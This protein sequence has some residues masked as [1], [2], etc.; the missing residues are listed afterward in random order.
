MRYLNLKSVRQQF[1]QNWKS[2]LWFQKVSVFGYLSPSLT[3]RYYSTPISLKNCYL[4]RLAIQHIY[5][6][7]QSK[8][9]TNSLHK[10]WFAKNPGTFNNLTSKFKTSRTDCT[11]KLIF[12]NSGTVKLMLQ[13]LTLLLKLLGNDIYLSWKWHG[14]WA[15]E[16][17][18]KKLLMSLRG[19][20][21]LYN[22]FRIIW[23]FVQ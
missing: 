18:L 23:W 10:I 1:L 12:L 4:Q 3:L 19:W 9:S 20:N 14:P 22:S 15:Q 11:A 21:R 7:I 13:V 5:N 2:F 8:F 16:N 17:L 6:N